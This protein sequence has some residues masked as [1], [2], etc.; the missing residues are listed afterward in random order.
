M[1]K[2]RETCGEQC[3]EMEHQ[4]ADGALGTPT[5]PGGNGAAG[6]AQVSPAHGN[7]GAVGGT[8][9]PGILEIVQVFGVQRPLLRGLSCW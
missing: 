9:S 6:E 8:G 3:R 1:A 7:F 2:S 5:A 4:N